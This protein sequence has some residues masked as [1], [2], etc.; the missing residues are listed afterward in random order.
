MELDEWMYKWEHA[1][2][3]TTRR[4]G[5][6]E[7][8]KKTSEPYEPRQYLAIS[9]ALLAYFSLSFS[10]SMQTCMSFVWT[11]FSSNVSRFLPLT[12]KPQSSWWSSMNFP[13]CCRTCTAHCERVSFQD[14][15]LLSE[16]SQRIFWDINH[17]SPQ[18]PVACNVT[19]LLLPSVRCKHL[20]LYCFHAP[21][22]QIWGSAPSKALQNTN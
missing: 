16:I 19:L 20:S 3:C 12:T 18:S 11:R 7:M 5:C 22:K 21:A 1:L 2:G 14:S 4:C 6:G 8:Y 13:D 10:L 17:S 9:P 15:I